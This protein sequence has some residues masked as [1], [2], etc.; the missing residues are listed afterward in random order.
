MEEQTEKGKGD[1]RSGWEPEE[2][3]GPA[4]GST[5]WSRRE[6]SSVSLS[7]IPCKRGSVRPA[8]SAPSRSR[9]LL[10]LD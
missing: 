5:P 7:L 3:K 4:H 10:W 8:L 1:R 6:E 2:P 9:A